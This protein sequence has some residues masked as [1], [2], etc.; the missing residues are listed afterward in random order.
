M[1]KQYS[2]ESLTG[3]MEVE[4]SYGYRRSKGW[5]IM[6]VN[7]IKSDIKDAT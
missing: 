6:H 7:V 2:E 5:N 3:I 4:D 1:C